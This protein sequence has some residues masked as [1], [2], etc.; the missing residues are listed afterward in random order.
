M[1]VTP[2]D[3][4]RI[5]KAGLYSGVP[6]SAYHGAD[7]CDGP[8]LSSSGLKTIFHKSP[9]HYWYASPYN[10]KRAEPDDSDALILGRAAHH[11]LLGEA[12]FDKHYVVR[13]EKLDGKA[14]NSNSGAC[15]DWLA[16]ASDLGLT[17]LTPA[18][19]DAIIGMRDG[20]REHPMVDPNGP[21]RLL[22]G[23]VEHTL[24]WKDEET[25]LWLK[26]RPDV[27]PLASDDGADL[28]TTADISDDG[29]ERMVGTYGVNQ[30]GA[31]V[32]EAW[33]QVFKRPLQGFS[34]VL[35]ESKPPHCARVKTLKPH[36]L[37]LGRMQN[38]M[39]LRLAAK[40]FQTGVWPGPGGTQTDAEFVEIK[41]WQ[42]GRIEARID[43]IDREINS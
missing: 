21:V 19:R 38:R 33:S 31:L 16:N 23:L 8:S 12:E 14:W 9:R 36:D 10:P 43:E 4:K 22:D 20:L 6:S 7:L 11:A 18:Q 2:W 3:G 30:Q 28:K 34:L 15:K 26:S 24:V 13:P 39:A 40:C 17:V 25:G 41:S 1:K 29:V 32:A 35:V 37:E 27:I 5:T 42:R